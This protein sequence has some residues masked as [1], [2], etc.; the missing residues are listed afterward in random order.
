[1]NYRNSTKQPGSASIE[2]IDKLTENPHVGKLL[3]DAYSGLRRVR[4]GSYRVLYETNENEVVV[5]VLRELHIE[6]R[7]TDNQF[8]E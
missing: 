8:S 1:M 4:S 7:S 2:T 5:L 6:K 3:K